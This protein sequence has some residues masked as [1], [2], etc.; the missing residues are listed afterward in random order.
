MEKTRS[1]LAL[2]TLIPDGKR[3]V[4]HSEKT[5]CG[6]RITESL[7]GPSSYHS[8]LSGR[9][10]LLSLS[11]KRKI[12]DAVAEIV[13]RYMKKFG[14]CRDRR[15]LF[16]GV[17]NENLTPDSLGPAVFGKIIATG[18]C[19]L[20]PSVFALKSGVPSRTGIDTADM[21]RASAE[22]VRAEL[23]VTADSLCASSYDRL[24]SVI[25]ITDIGMKPGSA[26]T[27]TSNEISR[28]TMPCP[29]ISV[30]VPTV[31]RSDVLC[32]CEELTDEPLLVS[33]ADCDCVISEYSTIIASALNRAFLGN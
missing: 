18:E 9:C 25:Q 19:E 8:V 27:H 22:L 33:T 31:I 17:G 16:C 6:C 11:E 15:I 32:G 5:V 7:S 12:S 28:S 26:F 23:I 20:T 3:N 29:V 14:I 4:L 30:G 13:S 10:H 2:E 1:D 21:I 24:S